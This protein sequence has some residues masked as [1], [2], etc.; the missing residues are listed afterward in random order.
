MDPTPIKTMLIPTAWALVVAQSVLLIAQVW[1]F[2]RLGVG[3]DTV[4][5]ISALVG[6][7]IGMAIIW[8]GAGRSARGVLIAAVIVTAFGVVVGLSGVVVV[9]LGAVSVLQGLLQLLTMSAPLVVPVI[10]LIVLI[11]LLPRTAQPPSAALEPAESPVTPALDSYG[12]EGDR[13]G[14]GTEPVWRPDQAAGV[15]WHTA[16]AAATGAAATWGTPG[17]S[18]SWTPAQTQESPTADRAVTGSVEEETRSDPGSP[19]Q[20]WLIATRRESPPPTPGAPQAPSN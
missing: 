9:V 5:W 6:L 2:L 12:Q 3:F 4:G 18:A 16:G 17:Q 15:A 11:R 10:V 20:G 7:V 19:D 14:E 1:W 8:G 13:A